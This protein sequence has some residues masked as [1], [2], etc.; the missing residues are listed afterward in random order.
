MERIEQQPS[1][2]NSAKIKD[3]LYIIFITFSITSVL[4]IS[5][6]SWYGNNLNFLPG[7][8]MLSYLDNANRVIKGSWPGNMPFYRAP[9]Y[10]Y[11]LAIMILIGQSLLGIQM[12]QCFIFSITNGIFYLCSQF[13]FNRATGWIS[14]LILLFYGAA[15][16]WV[17]ILHSAVFELFFASLTFYLF[18][19][20]R[21]KLMSNESFIFLIFYAL[22][23]SLSFALLCLIRPNFLVSGVML[24][25]ILFFEVLRKN[26]KKYF[27]TL[28][29]IIF[30][31]LSVWMPIGIHNYKYSGSPITGNALVTFKGAN[32]EGSG[33]YNAMTPVGKQLNIY[34]F[35]FW[36]HQF[37]KAIAYMQSPEYPQNV[38]YYLFQRH[39]FILMFLFLPFAFIVTLFFTGILLNYDLIKNIWP[40]YAYF[41]PYY[42]SISF[43]HIIGRFRI[44]GLTAMTIVSAITIFRLYVIFIEKKY[45]KFSTY[46][47]SI[48]IFFL[49]LNPFKS[50]IKGYSYRGLGVAA[51][52]EGKYN[53]ADTYLK[54]NKSDLANL[55]LL[56]CSYILQK[57]AHKAYKYMVKILDSKFYSKN[58]YLHT[59]ALFYKIMGKKEEYRTIEKKIPK[60]YSLKN[61]R[62]YAY[63]LFIKQYSHLKINTR[64]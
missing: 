7:T 19:I 64:F 49:L 3:F 28:V 27:I 5:I 24:L 29:I 45:L 55:E 42:L 22:L 46:I 23:F 26:T 53:E 1:I 41:F 34:S 8:D 4:T 50:I 21:K 31:I 17:L 38:C 61:D 60:N 16:F 63:I 54:R 33:V 51:L 56:V 43:F 39:S 9:L 36:K 12:I 20:Y 30:L 11:I 32:T 25:F 6:N 18:L 44:P 15:V 62:I 40:C 58:Q 48:L 57:D 2:K 59:M 35:N 37:K 47:V 13:L 14:S 52:M 10:S